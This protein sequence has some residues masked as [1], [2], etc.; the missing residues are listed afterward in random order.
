MSL[1]NVI[2]EQYVSESFLS[3]SSLKVQ[4]T[5]L[6]LSLLDR[7][8]ISDRNL[9][10]QSL[11]KVKSISK[12]EW[13]YSVNG[14]AN[15]NR[16]TKLYLHSFIAEDKKDVMYKII[17]SLDTDLKVYT[18]VEEIYDKR[19]SSIPH[20]I[21]RDILGLYVNLAQRGFWGL[22]KVKG[23]KVKVI[24]DYGIDNGRLDSINMGQAK[25]M[26]KF[27]PSILGGFTSLADKHDGLSI[28]T[29]KQGIPMGMTYRK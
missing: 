6:L 7:K 20:N 28:D 2:V 19:T 9:V 1:F 4:L 22:F 26:D 16:Q 23:N 18:R 11:K 14:H 25:N 10:L 12:V 5:P 17:V 27:L 13:I 3:S 29:N 8:K 21:V 15:D 24:L